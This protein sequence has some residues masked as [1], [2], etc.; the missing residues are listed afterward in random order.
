MGY[1]QHKKSEAAQRRVGT[2]RRSGEAGRG[3]ITYGVLRGWRL[4][5]RQ[6]EEVGIVPRGT[7]WYKQVTVARV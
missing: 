4:L 7:R 3:G 6:E 5:G 1:G 2:S